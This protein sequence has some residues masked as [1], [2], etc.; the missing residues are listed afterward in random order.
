MTGQNCCSNR[1][2][3]KST[4]SSR[5][6]EEASSSNTLLCSVRLLFCLSALSFIRFHPSRSQRLSRIDLTLSTQRLEAFSDSV[7]AI[8]LTLLFYNLRV[9]E[10]SNSEDWRELLNELLHPVASNGFDDFAGGNK[11]ETDVIAA[12]LGLPI[13]TRNGNGHV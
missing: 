13:S 9:P 8:V 7:F 1:K 3:R 11:A 5:L 10:L 12:M 6:A 2:S 4:R